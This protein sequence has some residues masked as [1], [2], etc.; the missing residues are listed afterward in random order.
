MYRL[1]VVGD[2]LEYGDFLPR[3]RY[4]DRWIRTDWVPASALDRLDAFRELIDR[5]ERPAVLNQRRRFF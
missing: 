1:T 4:F 3:T 5:Q 2:R